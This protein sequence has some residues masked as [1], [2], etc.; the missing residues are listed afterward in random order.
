MNQNK[1]LFAGPGVMLFSAAIFG[2]FG[3]Y[4][5]SPMNAA[6]QPILFM[7][8]LTWTLRGAA[9]LFVVSGVLTMVRPVLGNLL[10]FLVGG[11]GAGLFVVVVI[12]D[13]ADVQNQ[14]IHPLLLL[15]FAA[16]NGFGSWSALRSI[17]GSREQA[18]AA[19]GGPEPADGQ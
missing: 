18:V 11:V 4:M 8:L 2:F 10:Y 14:T 7:V 13:I 15:L 1:G 12:M 3:F 6:G 19:P 16:W 5:L 9:V 17:L